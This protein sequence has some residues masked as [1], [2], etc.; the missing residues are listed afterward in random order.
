MNLPSIIIA[1]VIAAVFA[2]I[3]AKGISNRNRG[4][5]SCA[6]G[7]DACAGRSLCHGGDS[8]AQK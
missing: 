8:A 1:L 5:S 3:V 4:K 7:C 6:C 2:A